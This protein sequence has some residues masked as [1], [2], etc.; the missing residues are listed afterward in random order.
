MRARKLFIGGKV[1]A[2]RA[3]HGLTQAAFATRL[4][5]S[6]SYLNQ[7]ENNQRHVSASVL[8][9]LAEAFSVDITTLSDQDTDRLL[10]DVSEALAD[11]VSGG[12]QPSLADIKLVV[13]NAPSFARAF[14]SLHQ[15]MRRS[16]D[17]LA[18]L[19]QTLERSGAL[20]EPTPY[21]EV[22]DF[23]H[24]VDNYIHELDIAGERLSQELAR[25]RGVSLKALADHIERRHRVRVAIGPGAGQGSGPGEAADSGAAGLRRFDPVSRVLW[26]NPRTPVATQAF[27]IACQIALIEHEATMTRI[28]SEAKFRSADAAG[29]CR[30]GLA[31]Y[32]AGA[33][34][35]PYGA[36]S[37][38]ARE[39]R[40]DLVLLADRFSTS[41][42]QVAHR[43]STLQRPGQKGVPFFFARVDKAGNITKRHSATKLQFA[44]FG[45]AC[46]LWNAHGAFETPNRIIRQLAE[47]PDGVRY[48]CLATA[49]SKPSG[50]WHDPVQ[51]YAL[52]LGCEVAHA[53][54]L[55]Y[56]D[57]LD[58]ARAEAFEPIGVS[59]RICERRDCHQRAVPPLKRRLVVDPNTRKAV[60]YDVE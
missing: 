23:F 32:F 43:L 59:C 45:S 19:D 6:T 57:D 53:G 4:G 12:T 33:T 5:I 31:N 24:Y 26:L 8:L 18:E 14:L 1:R 7:I 42:E 29:I 50:G 10:A 36:F 17:Q 21:E 3:E 9:A 30:I 35:L 27:Q 49:V 40:H 20:T 51:T 41:L 25:S 38:A 46:P 55:V 52:A 2:I 47:T 15:A 11:P 39:L 13:Q 16:G 56:A 58:I 37:A 44:R 28:I 60:P 34:I 22:R 48:L 54:E